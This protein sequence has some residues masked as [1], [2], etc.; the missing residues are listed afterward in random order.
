[1]AELF[2]SM[3]FKDNPFSTFSAEEEKDYLSQIYFN[4][5][6]YDTLLSD[7]E[8][9]NSRYLIGARGSGKTA[10]ILRLKEQLSE[11]NV[12]TLVIDDFEGIPIKNNEVQFVFRI[13]SDLILNYCFSIRSTPGL[14]KRLDKNEREKLSFIIRYFFKTISK[15][16]YES[17]YDQV[18]KFKTKNLFKNIY[19]RILNRPINFLISG[20][21]EIVGDTVSKAFGLPNP[22][23]NTFY[24][25]YLPEI[26]LEHIE[27]ERNLERHLLNYKTLKDILFDLSSIIKKSGFRSTVIFFDKI[28]EYT[29]LNSNISLVSQ[30]LETFLRDTTILMNKE[31]SLVFSIW[32][33]MKAELTSKGVRFDK[34]KPVDI[35]W[36][37]ENIK[38]ILEKRLKYF[39]GNNIKVEDIISQSEELDDIIKLSNNSP[40]YLLRLLSNVYDEQSMMDF[41]VKK[42]S[43]DSL[44]Q[45]KYKYATQF[46]YYSIYPTKRNTKED[47]RKNINRLLKIG[48]IEIKTKDFVEVYRVSTATAI[49]YIKIMLNYD[50]IEEKEDI[51]G[52]QKNYK[53]KD[54]IIEFL[55]NSN[56]RE[57]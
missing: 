46:D 48:K 27:N 1:M 10:L 33:V 21:V 19:N 13:L 53:V 8:K 11:Q 47:I 2:R 52:G 4:P 7:L 16:E 42:F 44:E 15:R 26:P 57:L 39:S 40:R 20:A 6:Y 30:F 12:L 38:R 17:H 49:S 51:M 54:P 56:V 28:D 9:G 5:L 25:N 34:I 14:L 23:S 32:D 3:G 22:N 45:G 35:T 36:T 24:K 37:A 31:M 29:K 50:L 41:K 43:V 55:I 18:T